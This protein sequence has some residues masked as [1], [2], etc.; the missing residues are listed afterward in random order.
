MAIK[1]IIF[2]LGGVLLNLNKEANAEVFNTLGATGYKDFISQI[3]TIN[4]LNQHEKGRLSSSEL[5]EYFKKELDLEVSDVQFDTAYNALLLN[6]PKERFDLLEKLKKHYSL[7][8]LSNTNEI[9]FKVIQ[10]I[11]RRD[12]GEY[13]FNSLFVAQYY[14]H[15]IHHRKPD[16]AAFQHI[17]NSHHLEPDE[18]L[19]IDDTYENIATAKILGLHAIHITCENDILDLVKSIEEIQS[20][21]FEKDDSS[22]LDLVMSLNI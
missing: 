11:Y 10:D 1:H 19:F 5:R 12:Q 16:A 15:L 9:H 14:S 3:K 6:I 7:Y 20:E 13:D 18:T 22:L 21:A 17:L 8:L 4:V 2:D